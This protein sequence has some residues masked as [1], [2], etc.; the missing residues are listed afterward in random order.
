MSVS[1][2]TIWAVGRSL[3]AHPHVCTEMCTFARRCAWWVRRVLRSHGLGITW[4]PVPASRSWSKTPGGGGGGVCVPTQHLAKRAIRAPGWVPGPHPGEALGDCQ[5]PVSGIDRDRQTWRVRWG[6]HWSCIVAQS[7]AQSTIRCWYEQGYRRWLFGRSLCHWGRTPPDPQHASLLS[8]SHWIHSRC[9]IAQLTEV[10]TEHQQAG[11]F[12]NWIKILPRLCV[13]KKCVLRW[14]VKSR[15]PQRVEVS[16]Q[17]RAE[18]R[19]SSAGPCRGL[20]SS[21]ALGLSM[22][23]QQI[24]RCSLLGQ[25]R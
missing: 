3:L 5:C 6:H 13:L 20:H 1:E 19:P 24:C 7:K 10:T 2:K 21:A 8:L 14:W 22:W 15:R 11:L 16:E 18:R 17:L 4:W 23:N 9:S 12:Q 25:E